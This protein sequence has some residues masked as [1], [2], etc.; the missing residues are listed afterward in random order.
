MH[1]RCEVFMFYDSK[2][3]V[4]AFPQTQRQAKIDVPEIQISANCFKTIHSYW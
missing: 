1:A 2:I 3:M 4:K